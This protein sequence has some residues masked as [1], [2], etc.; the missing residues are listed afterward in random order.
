MMSGTPQSEYASRKRFSR[1]NAQ[2]R[3]IRRRSFT[4]MAKRGGRR[5]IC[6]A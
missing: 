5:S 4:W 3:E 6:A 2:S 1:W